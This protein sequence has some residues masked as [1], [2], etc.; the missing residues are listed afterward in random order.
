MNEKLKELLANIL[1]EQYGLLDVIKGQ[2]DIVHEFSL[3]ELY[4]HAQ[5]VDY[6]ADFFGIP[7]DGSADMSQ[8]ELGNGMCDHGVEFYCRD[9]LYQSIEDGC[10]DFDGDCELD[11]FKA[12]V[13]SMYE[14]GESLKGI[15][16]NTCDK[17]IDRIGKSIDHLLT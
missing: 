13:Q 16:F 4:A 15:H 8:K 1:S 17:C 14:E 10:Q 11:R 12:F 5:A 7:N 6:V 3:G 9:W 2:E